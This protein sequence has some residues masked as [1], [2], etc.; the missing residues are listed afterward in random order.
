MMNVIFSGHYFH[1]L[2]GLIGNSLGLKF[3]QCVGLAQ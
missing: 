2:L 3:F 1:E